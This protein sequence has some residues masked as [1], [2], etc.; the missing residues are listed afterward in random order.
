M[1]C[2]DHQDGTSLESWCWWSLLHRTSCFQFLQSAKKGHNWLTFSSSWKPFEAALMD[3]NRS[4]SFFFFILL[5]FYVVSNHKVLHLPEVFGS[6][7]ISFCHVDSRVFNTSI[8]VMSFCIQ[9]LVLYFNLTRFIPFLWHNSV[10]EI[11]GYLLLLCK[12]PHGV[13]REKEKEM[14]FK[15]SSVWEGTH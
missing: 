8:F 15:I 9:I 7:P 11:K 14:K 1:R 5:L 12:L 6:W 2:H 13:W 3:I 4:H 10:E